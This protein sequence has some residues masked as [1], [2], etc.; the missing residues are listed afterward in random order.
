MQIRSKPNNGIIADDRSRRLAIP[1]IRQSH[2]SPIRLFARQSLETIER[3]CDKAYREDLSLDILVVHS[4]KLRLRQDAD[5]VR[6][7]G[8]LDISST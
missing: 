6:F 3:M 1:S 2:I 8:L 7:E 4:H 5:V